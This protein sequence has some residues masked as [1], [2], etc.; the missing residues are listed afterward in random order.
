M[1]SKYVKLVE[2]TLNESKPL[3]TSKTGATVIERKDVTNTKS[4][5]KFMI[6]KKDGTHFSTHPTLEGA[7][8]MAD[9]LVGDKLT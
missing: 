1:T 5:D 8:K 7:K 3:Y 2:E 9:R 6:H 4:Q